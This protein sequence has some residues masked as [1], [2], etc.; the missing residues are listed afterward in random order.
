MNKSSILK[1]TSGILLMLTAISAV[2]PAV[3]VNGF[4]VTGIDII[5]TGLGHSAPAAFG[6]YGEML[7]TQLTGAA[8]VTLVSLLVPIVMGFVACLMKRPKGEKVGIIGAIITMILW[9][10]ALFVIRMGFSHLANL[11]SEWG[12]ELIIMPGIVGCVL[13]IV[14]CIAAAVLIKMSGI[15]GEKTEVR[16]KVPETIKLQ[17]ESTKSRAE[18]GGVR[19]QAVHTRVQQETENASKKTKAVKA[20]TMGSLAGIDQESGHIIKLNGLEERGLLF[21]GHMVDL[22]EINDPNCVCSIKFDAKTKQYM[23]HPLK[24]EAVFYGRMKLGTKYEFPIP[25]GRNISIGD[26]THVFKLM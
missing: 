17:A 11:L 3:T 8:V 22:G 2:L 14:L 10:A 16:D 23:L 19:E 24:M 25:A 9:L 1:V 26:I 20:A 4:K 7:S 6:F 12:S 15:T 18:S 13:R 21:D 5:K